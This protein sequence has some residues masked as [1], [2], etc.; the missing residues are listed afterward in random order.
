MSESRSGPGTL[1]HPP[2]GFE[3]LETPHGYGWVRPEVAEWWRSLLAGGRTLYEGGGDQMRG[4]TGGNARLQGRAP[5]LVLDSEVGQVAVRRYMRGGAVAALLGDR[6]LRTGVPRPFREAQASE[7][8]RSAGIPTPRVI[9]ATCY[10][11][12]LFY[13]CD[14]ATELIPNGTDLGEFL[15]G[16][17]LLGRDGEGLPGEPGTSGL[18]RDSEE[19]LAALRGALDLIDRLAELG[20][21]HPDLNV[22]NFLVQR[23]GSGN[24]LHLLD[25]DRCGPTGRGKGVIRDAMRARFRTSLEKWE[26]GSG[27]PLS[28]EERALVE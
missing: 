19:R 10:P 15:F 2:E 12:G 28:R 9:A 13:R 26:R 1:P 16:V 3:A 27:R 21:A 6:Y 5:V 25:L 20:M 7:R 23:G 18:A 8:L 14:I 22:K 24:P 17:T 11:H 4:R